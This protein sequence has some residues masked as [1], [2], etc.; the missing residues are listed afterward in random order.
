MVER[1]GKGSQDKIDDRLERRT[2]MKRTVLN[3]SIF[4]FAI[5]ILASVHLAEAQQAAQEN[6]RFSGAT[7]DPLLFKF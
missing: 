6:S 4:L 7:L 2:M 1:E 3:L 5:V